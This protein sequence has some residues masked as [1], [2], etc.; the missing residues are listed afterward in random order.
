VKLADCL[1]ALLP[2]IET[3]AVE[4]LEESTGLL[5][6]ILMKVGRLLGVQGIL[7]HY[8]WREV[9]MAGI[10]KHRVFAATSTGTGGDASTKENLIAE[11]K[12]G[13]ISAK[14]LNYQIQQGKLN[15]SMIYNGAYGEPR[16][17]PYAK[18]E[19]FFGLFDEETEECL[20][21]YKAESN[22][23]VHQLLRND[24]SRSIGKTT[25]LN[26]AKFRLELG[27]ANIVYRSD[28]FVRLVDAL[29]PQSRLIIED[30]KT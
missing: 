3:Y 20:L 23:I 24:Q 18:Q 6:R 15:V 4:D 5:V 14:D 22:E 8:K 26:T 2:T 27:D 1:R 10:L 13:K 17:T 30:S 21:I 7:R 28:L 16:I 12:T 25:N 11:Y 9:A 29:H 19:H